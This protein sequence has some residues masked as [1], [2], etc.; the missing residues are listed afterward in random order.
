VEPGTALP[1]PVEVV[2]AAEQVN[3]EQ[4]GAR[5]ERD[6]DVAVAARRESVLPRGHVVGAFGPVDHDPVGGIAE[7]G[8][9]LDLR[10]I[11]LG[12]RARAEEPLTLVERQLLVRPAKPAIEMESVFAVVALPH[13]VGTAPKE[14]GPRR[15]RGLPSRPG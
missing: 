11:R 10:E 15:C 8:R 6:V 9:D 7:R 4:E 1:A 14:S 2:V 13:G 3:L 5:R 12:R